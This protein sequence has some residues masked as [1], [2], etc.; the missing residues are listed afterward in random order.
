MT[1]EAYVTD[2]RMITTQQVSQLES[3]ESRVIYP[4][5]N[6]SLEKGAKSEPTSGSS[7]SAQC[8]NPARESSVEGMGVTVS[9]CLHGLGQEAISMMVDLGKDFV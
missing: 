7:K 6:A 4:G 3:Y 9:S 8:F 1:H 5:S 2:N